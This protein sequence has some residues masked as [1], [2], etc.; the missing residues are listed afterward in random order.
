M[1]CL[2][3]LV[4][5]FVLIVIGLAILM[6]LLKPGEALPRIGALLVVLLAGPAVI[7]SL[8]KAVVVP[9]AGGVWSATKHLL[10]VAAFSLCLLLIAW[11]V[12]GVIETYRNR[13]S[14]ENR[15]QLGGE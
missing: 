2:I 3:Q 15:V 4:F 10:V 12:A 1:T 9:V 7:N 13:H 8:V 11:L 6:R 14:G 5:C